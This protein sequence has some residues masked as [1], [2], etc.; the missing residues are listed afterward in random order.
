MMTPTFHP[1]GDRALVFELGDT[2]RAETNVH[3]IEMADRL[4]A[5]KWPGVTEVVPTYRSLLVGYDPL[6]LRGAEL[7]ARLMALWENRDATQP[8]KGRLWTV[9]CLYGAGVEGEL[10]ALA[11][12][13][14]LSADELIALHSGAEYRVYMIGFAPG[15]VY[16]GGLPE[17][18]HTPRLPVPRQNIPAGAIG[19]GG[20]QANI[21]SVSG[22]SGWRFVGWTPWRIFDPSVSEPFLLRAGDRVRFAPIS[23]AEAQEITTALAHGAL[24]P[25]PEQ[26]ARQD[27]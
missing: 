24:S 26:V 19:I 17:V 3:I 14:E 11:Q 6:I 27:D 22:P 21:N 18:L 9:P 1:A 5:Q 20:Q 8:P 15:F 12:M 2:I 10:A 4:E 16:L 23:V 13:K 25:R 7:E